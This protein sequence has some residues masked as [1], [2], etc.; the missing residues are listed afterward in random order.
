MEADPEDTYYLPSFPELLKLLISIKWK[1]I[2]E[3]TD[4]LNRI[5]KF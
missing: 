4:H 1:T 3:S 5:I 2:A